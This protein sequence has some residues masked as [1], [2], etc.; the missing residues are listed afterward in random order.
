LGSCYLSAFVCGLKSE[1]FLQ[2]F[3]LIL[4]NVA[5]RN[6]NNHFFLSVFHF[7]PNCPC[8]PRH[9]AGVREIQGPFHPEGRTA[10]VTIVALSV[11]M[12]R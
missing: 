6:Q 3:Y 7:P 8:F 1:F 9:L 12:F 2:A 10:P 4:Q 11:Q 5:L